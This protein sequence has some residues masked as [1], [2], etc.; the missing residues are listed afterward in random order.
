VPVADSRSL[1]HLVARKRSGAEMVS[2]SAFAVLSRVE[3]WR[4]AP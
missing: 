2:P 4:K 1:N 3:D